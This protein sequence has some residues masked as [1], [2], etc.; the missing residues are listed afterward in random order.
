MQKIFNFSL[1]T[2]V[3]LLSVFLFSF[4]SFAKTDLSLTATDI[5]LSKDEPLAGETIKVFARVFNLGDTDVYGFVVFSDNGKE[6]A[7]PQPI[8]VKSNTY[9]DVFIDWLAPAG[10][11]DV[12]AKIVATNLADENS[13]N[14]KAIRENYFVDSDIDGDGV[15]NSKDTDDD[16]DGLTDGQE[17]ALGT[18]SLDPDSDGDRVRDGIDIFPLD[19]KEW[20]DSDQD[21]LGDN[22]DS[23]NDNDGLENDEEIFVYGTN[24]LNSDSDNDRLSDKEEVNLG[25]N[26]LAADTDKDGVID[27]E[28]KFPLDSS[29]AQA[30]LLEAAKFFAKNRGIPLP[31]FIGGALLVLLFIFMLFRKKR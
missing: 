6:I 29:K 21:G 13:A 18:D 2:A 11:H 30:S 19:A 20:R 25:T 9:D 4:D 10:S 8:S 31:Y 23:D 5:A 24:P 16:N 15:G 12:Q 1:T 26:A 28:D 17:I 22:Q 3:I 7:D 27:S 14:D